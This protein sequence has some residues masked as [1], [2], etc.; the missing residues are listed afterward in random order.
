LSKDNS[1][2]D[3]QKSTSIKEQE[4][5]NPNRKWILIVACFIALFAMY[6]LGMNFLSTLAERELLKAANSEL[7]PNAELVIGDLKLRLFPASLT[8]REVKLNHLEP[9]EETS[10]EKPLDTIRYFYVN[11]ADLRGV[12]LFRLLRGEDWGIRSL[13][14]DGLEAGVVPVSERRLTDAEPFEAPLTFTIGEFNLKNA[15]FSIY[16]ERDSDEYTSRAEQLSVTLSEIQVKD[17]GEPLHS[18][19]SSFSLYAGSVRHFTENGFYE[20]EMGELEVSDQS[21]SI[22]AE[23]FE[24]K[25]RLSPYEAASKKEHAI[26]L[27]RI[28]SGPL[29]FE[30][31]DFGEWLETGG[32]NVSYGELDSLNIEIDRD[33]T[34]PRPDRDFQPMPNAELAGLSFSISADSIRW[35]NGFLSYTELFHEKDRSGSITFDD[36]DLLLTGVQNSN[37]SEPIKAGATA[38]FME[39]A[40]LNAEFEFYP[41]ESARHRV[42]ASLGGMDFSVLNE[43]L[44]NLALVEVKSGSLTT[45]EFEFE[46]DDDSS[47]GEMTLLYDELELRFLDDDSLEEG[48]RNRIT[49]FIANTFAVRSSNSED[50]PRTGTMEYERDKDRSMFNFWWRSIEAGIKDTVI[51][52]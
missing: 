11:R 45:L 18:Y 12:R 48:F 7:A 43:T 14:I 5:K 32:L 26:D 44:K 21:R 4:V 9:F 27:F 25:P 2:A 13:T 28:K 17:A 37:G 42:K 3:N 31:F 20:I 36:I 40:E 6:L 49:S 47:S 41:V 22:V 50:D 46:A 1:S 39:S 19:F 51:R 24:L 35:K 23:S 29:S 15:I 52:L 30:R 38:S 34:Y 8:L 33:R 10:P 16:S